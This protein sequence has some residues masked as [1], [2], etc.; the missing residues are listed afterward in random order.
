MKIELKLSVD[1]SIT[2]DELEQEEATKGLGALAKFSV[3][4]ADDSGLPSEY[5]CVPKRVRA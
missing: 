4:L 2:S 3:R 5:P 1:Q